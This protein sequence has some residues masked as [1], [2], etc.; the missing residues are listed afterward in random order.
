MFGPQGDDAKI[1]DLTPCRY[2]SGPYLRLDERQFRTVPGS[3][4]HQDTQHPVA[5]CKEVA[6]HAVVLGLLVG[7]FMYGVRSL[8]LALPRTTS[9]PG[10]YEGR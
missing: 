9:I 8:I 6:R 5:V 7:R 1:E 10:V 3:R 4:F 2:E